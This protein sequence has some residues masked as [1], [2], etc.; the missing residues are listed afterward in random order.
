MK[1]ANDSDTPPIPSLEDMQHWTWVME[2]AQQMMLEHGLQT[3]DDT[4]AL[5]T[6]PGFTDKATMARAPD[7]WLNRLKLWQSSRDPP[8]A[9]DRTTDA[10]GTSVT[11]V[12]NQGCATTTKKKT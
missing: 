1:V 7:Y 3:L 9:P 6:I 12:Y 5:P 10:Y 8:R 4:P 2:R 11:S